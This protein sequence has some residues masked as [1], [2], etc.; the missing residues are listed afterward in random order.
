MFEIIGKL[1]FYL[2][3]IYLILKLMKGFYTTYLGN[4]LGFGVI[5]KPSHETWAI[6]TGGNNRSHS[7]S[8]SYHKFYV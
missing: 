8:L 3:L 4:A 5:W 7:K 6:V 2:I 1:T